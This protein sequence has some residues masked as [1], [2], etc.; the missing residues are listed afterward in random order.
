MLLLNTMW[1]ENQKVTT[2][3]KKATRFLSLIIIGFHFLKFVDGK[4]VLTFVTLILLLLILIQCIQGK[5]TESDLRVNDNTVSKYHAAISLHDGEFYI[6]DLDSKYGTSILV[7][8]PEKLF[9]SRGQDLTLQVDRSTI[10]CHVDSIVRQ[11]PAKYFL[12]FCT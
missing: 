3:N 9:I 5:A 6:K 2:R 4:S 11:I 10:K 12:Y 7:D 1:E 8:E